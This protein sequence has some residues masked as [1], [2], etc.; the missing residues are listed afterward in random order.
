MEIGFS[1]DYASELEDNIQKLS[2]ALKSVSKLGSVNILYF[3][4]DNDG[5]EH[6]HSIGYNYIKIDVVTNYESCVKRFSENSYDIFLVDV[7]GSNR[8]SAIKFINFLKSND[9]YKPLVVFT[10]HC[11][12]QCMDECFDGGA[13]NFLEKKDLRYLIDNNLFFKQMLSMA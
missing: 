6:V 12:K 10:D 7:F 13:T 9:N 1:K 4:N 8:A 3:E 2:N 11:S 5:Y